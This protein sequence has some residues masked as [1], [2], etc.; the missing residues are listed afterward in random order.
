MKRYKVQWAYAKEIGQPTIHTSEANARKEVE[1]LLGNWIA[2]RIMDYVSP[3][4]PEIARV[5]K[6]GSPEFEEGI[7]FVAAE[8]PRLI[9]EG[10]TWEAYDLWEDFYIRFQNEFDYPLF[11]TLGTVIVQGTPETGLKNRVPFL[12]VT[13]NPAEHFRKGSGPVIAIDQFR[14]RMDEVVLETMKV[15]ANKAQLKGIR[16]TREQ[17]FDAV[18]STIRTLGDK[19]YYFDEETEKLFLEELREGIL[20]KLFPKPS[21]GLGSFLS[22]LTGGSE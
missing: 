4:N 3:R 19:Y 12:E 20:R 7:R 16:L 18:D 21:V 1:H 11:I 13:E 10:H 8:I 14:S 15:A 6:H 17:F 5:M 22:W 2:R 9:R